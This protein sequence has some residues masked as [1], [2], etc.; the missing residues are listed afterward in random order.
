MM[1]N[2]NPEKTSTAVRE[3]FLH[4]AQGFCK[5]HWKLL[6]AAAGVL[7]IGGAVVGPM[8]SP[9]PPQHPPTTSNSRWNGGTS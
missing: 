5:R 8:L 2:E 4:R 7:V 1:Q 3:P 6:A 9:R